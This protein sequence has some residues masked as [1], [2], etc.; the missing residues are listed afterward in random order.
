MTNQRFYEVLEKNH[1]CSI[2]G[3]FYEGFGNNA[4]PINEGRCC[5]ACNDMYVIPQRILKMQ[6][7]M[8][9]V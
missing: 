9:E 2:C 3:K 8:K 7:D 5:D 6:Y 4:D 1:V